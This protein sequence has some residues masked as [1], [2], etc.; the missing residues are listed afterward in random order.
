[1]DPGERRKVYQLQTSTI[2]LV[3]QDSEPGWDGGNE[4]EVKE[5]A[6][7]GQT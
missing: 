1:M 5:M 7:A 6:V 2:V 4:M 3:S